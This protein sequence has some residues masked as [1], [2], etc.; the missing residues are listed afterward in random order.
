MILPH[1]ASTG[2]QFSIGIPEHMQMRSITKPRLFFDTNVCSHLLGEPYIRHYP[3]ISEAIEQKYQMAVSPETFIELMVGWHEGDE[4][5]FH[6]DL[7]KIRVM[8]GTGKPLF[9]PVC[10]EFSLGKTLGVKKFAALRPLVF[11]RW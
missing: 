11:E 6:D 7:A 8:A 1:P 4:G 5:H 10:G 3:A 2:F 9:L